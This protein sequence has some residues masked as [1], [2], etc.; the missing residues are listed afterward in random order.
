MNDI[1]TQKGGFDAIPQAILDKLTR[2]AMPVVRGVEASEQTMD[3]AGVTVP[4]YECESL[5]LGSGAAGMR[6]A[7]ELILSA[8]SSEAMNLDVEPKRSGR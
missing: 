6:A 1:K 7:V 3:V 2:F 8:P 5:V 4:V